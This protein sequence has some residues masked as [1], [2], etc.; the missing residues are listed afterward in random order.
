MINIPGIF[1]F[2]LLFHC[3]LIRAYYDITDFYTQEPS[4]VLEGCRKGGVPPGGAFSP[5]NARVEEVLSD[6]TVKLNIN[7]ISHHQHRDTAWSPGTGRARPRPLGDDDDDGGGAA[8][9]CVAG[10]ERSLRGGGGGGGGRRRA[11][12]GRRSVS[13]WQDANTA[14]V[15]FSPPAIH[16]L[17]KQRGRMQ[18]DWKL[19]VSLS[20]DDDDDGCDGSASPLAHAHAQVSRAAMW[21]LMVSSVVSGAGLQRQQSGGTRRCCSSRWST[22]CSTALRWRSWIRLYRFKLALYRCA[23]QIISVLAPT[24]IFVYTVCVLCPVP[25]FCHCTQHARK[26]PGRPY[27]SYLIKEL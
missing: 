8:L 2:S 19:Q 5:L 12:E 17:L 16:E 21:V 15:T 11:T 4:C 24:C 25:G 7:T 26:A 3:G 13:G 23:R 1:N 6:V 20:D 27:G 14:A 9:T 10:I 22:V 18:I